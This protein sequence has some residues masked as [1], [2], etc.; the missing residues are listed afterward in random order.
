MKTDRR[1]NLILNNKIRVCVMK[2]GTAAG[3]F[4]ALSGCASIVS[5]N[6]YPVRIESS[7]PGVDFVI[8]DAS[9]GDVRAS[10]RTPQTV[11][12]KSGGD[13]FASA[14]YIL[15]AEKK[16]YRKAS[17]NIES[18]LDPWYIGNVALGWLCV[19]GFI[20]DPITGAMW[21]MPDHVRVDIFPESNWSSDEKEIAGAPI[22]KVSSRVQ[23][24]APGFKR[25][26]PKK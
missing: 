22:G 18:S 4:V 6:T 1:K 17:Q 10:G 26:A 14:E 19:I 5:E 21:E 23:A 11:E 20:V 16:G 9:S 2:F 24:S 7:V 15:E 8:R 25:D 3:V 13:F 12:L